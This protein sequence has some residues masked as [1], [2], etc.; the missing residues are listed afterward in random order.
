M[1]YRRNYRRRR[2]GRRRG[3]GRRGGKRMIKRI[4]AKYRKQGYGLF[5]LRAFKALSST[6]GGVIDNIFSVTNPNDYDGLGAPT[7]ILQDWSNLVNLY[8]EYCV[9]AI[10]IKYIPYF[11]N[12]DST[13]T[14]TPFAPL[15]SVIDFDDL[16]PLPNV[17]TAIQ[18]ERMKVKNLWRPFKLYY[19]IPKLLNL[20]TTSTIISPGWMDT[21]VTQDT[22]A[23]KFYSGGVGA[24]TDYGQIITTYYIVTKNRR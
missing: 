21:S 17:N 1:P 8:D 16:T 10:S 22:G 13:I 14:T 12:N 3:F 23:I 9:K 7:S 4:T 20:A 2:F 5:K 19:K 24:S 15:Y 11:P 6:A 18:Y